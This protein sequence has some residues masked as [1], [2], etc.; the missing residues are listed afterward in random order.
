MVVVEGL[1]PEERGRVARYWWQRAAGEMTSWVGWRHVLSDLRME[2]SPSPV[3]ELA[4]RAVADEHRHAEW[5]RDFAMR[6]GH[7]GGEILPRGEA[8]I[9]FRGASERQNRLLRIALCTFTE[10]VGCFT[11]TKVREVVTDADLRKQNQQH[12]ADE[13]QHSRTGWAHLSTLDASARD[14]LRSALPDLFGLLSRVCCDGEELDD[15]TLVPWGYFTKALLK[16]AHDEALRDV[17]V[18]GLAHV[19]IV[20]AA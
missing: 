17:I 9:A 3:V 6:F 1:T 16:D 5:C 7:P 20:E 14:F 15:A 4:E 11:L 13:L 8:P 2:G 10:S 12:L 19:H 18:P